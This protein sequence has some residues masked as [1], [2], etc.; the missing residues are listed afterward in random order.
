MRVV[1]LNESQD[2]P[3]GVIEFDP[4]TA[5]ETLF[6]QDGKPAFDERQPRT[7]DREPM[8]L[9]SP[10]TISQIHRHFGGV[11]HPQG[12]EDDVD[13]VQLRNHP[14]QEAQEFNELGRA[15]LPSDNARD[16]AGREGER[17]EQISRSMADIFELATSGLVGGDR[18][19]GSRRFPDTD[20]GLLINPEK[21]TISGGIEL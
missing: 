21:G 4:L 14:I 1:R 2:I 11:M 8:E 5:I 16:Q 10:R 7:V 20:P 19:A 18:L 15:M 6:A 12:V 13:D 17:R 3:G 9:E